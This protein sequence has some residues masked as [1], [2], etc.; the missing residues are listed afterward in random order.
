VTQFLHFNFTITIKKEEQ[1]TTFVNWLPITFLYS[2]SNVALL[3]MER[4]PPGGTIRV[5]SVFGFVTS[6]FIERNGNVIHFSNCKHKTSGGGETSFP[7][8]LVLLII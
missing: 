8:A 6:S 7:L 1:E 2:S 5:I 3:T 4:I